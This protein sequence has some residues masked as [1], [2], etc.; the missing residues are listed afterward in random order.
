[1]Q[2]VVAFCVEW[3]GI[4]GNATRVLRLNDDKRLMKSHRS[5]T[6]VPLYMIW[7]LFDG[8]CVIGMLGS[9]ATSSRNQYHGTAR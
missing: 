5:M 8:R 7:A 9:V 3:N 1:M 4:F 6:T 2:C